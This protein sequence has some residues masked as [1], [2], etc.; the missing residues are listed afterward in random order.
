MAQKKRGE[1]PRKRPHNLG[2]EHKGN[3]KD[4]YRRQRGGKSGVESFRV[5]PQRPASYSGLVS[6]RRRD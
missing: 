1:A 2:S 5:V 3:A 6:L 4:A